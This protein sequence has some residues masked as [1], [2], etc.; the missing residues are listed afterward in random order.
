MRLLIV[1]EGF[2]RLPDVQMDVSENRSTVLQY[3]PGTFISVQRSI[4]TLFPCRSLIVLVLPLTRIHQSR[5]CGSRPLWFSQD[6]TGPN[7]QMCLKSRL[8][9]VGAELKPKVSKLALGYYS[10]V[11]CWAPTSKRG[12]ASSSR[13]DCAIRYIL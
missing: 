8:H 13:S 9:Y 7:A 12:K 11:R 2:C 5:S 6:A 10:L 1:A 3:P 4:K